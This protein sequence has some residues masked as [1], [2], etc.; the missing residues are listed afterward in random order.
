MGRESIH[1]SEH[2]RTKTLNLALSSYPLKVI[3][4]HPNILL[5]IP[6]KSQEKS[7]N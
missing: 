3:P 5:C 2:T 1:F 6:G 7:K 4:L